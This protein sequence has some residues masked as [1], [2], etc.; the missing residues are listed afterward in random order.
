MALVK[1]SKV[2]ISYPNLFQPRSF[3]DGEP[4]FSA[5]FVFAPD[6]PAAKLIEAATL[7]AAETTWPGKGAAT[8]KQLKAAGR[9]FTVRDGDEK[10]SDGYAG[11]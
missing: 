9:V 7:A 4:K 5:S 11:N 8:L 2:R 6:H 3:Q 10:D 1:L